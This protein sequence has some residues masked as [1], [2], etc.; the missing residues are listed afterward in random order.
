MNDS[1]SHAAIRLVKTY[2]TYFVVAFDSMEYCASL[3]NLRSVEGAPNFVFVKA[4]V[5]GAR[6]RLVCLLLN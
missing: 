1:G 6:G 4:S 3:K 5:G 2:P